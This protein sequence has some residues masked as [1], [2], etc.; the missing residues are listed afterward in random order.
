MKRS[1]PDLPGL[2]RN[3]HGVVSREQLLALGLTPDALRHR[4]RPG[5]PWQR[6]LPSVY[7][8]VTG[9]PTP[10]QQEMALRFHQIGSMRVSAIDVLV[11]YHR[12]RVS[13]GFAVLHRT[14]RMPRLVPME[15]E[16][17][18]VLP[19]RAVVDTV[20]GLPQLSDA[21][22]IVAAAVQL[23]RCT[24]ADLAEELRG[25][26][27]HRD[28]LLREVLAEVAAGIRSAPEGDLRGLVRQSGLPTPMYNPKLYLLGKFLAQPDAWWQDAGV[29]AEVDSRT[30]HLSPEGW[31]NTMRRHDRMTAAGILLLHF[32]PAQLRTE[33][34][35][36]VRQIA[37]ALR[38]GRPIAG[39][40]ARPVA[41]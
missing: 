19:E 26:H 6:L 33:P 17:A 7:L 22:A 1:E 30:F 27:T 34:Q 12:Q 21:R 14:R 40:T 39:M 25:R 20:T 41:A 9:Q 18:F 38:S 23:R 36:V 31:A 37:T 4:I 11:P 32:T 15:G 16:R 28:A 35:L 2:L 5:G 13:R 10:E 8:T 24:V 3:Q 29:A